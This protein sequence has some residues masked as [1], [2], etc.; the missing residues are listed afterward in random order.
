[1]ENSN[2]PQVDIKEIQRK[3]TT[4]DKIFEEFREYINNDVTFECYKKDV[5]KFLSY[6]RGRQEIS[7]RS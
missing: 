5:F 3:Y 2:A 7:C 6:L 1:M 4:T